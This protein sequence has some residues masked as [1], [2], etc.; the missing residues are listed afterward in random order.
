[1]AFVCLFIYIFCVNYKTVY[2]APMYDAT[3]RHKCLAQM[4]NTDSRP[5][6]PVQ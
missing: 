4:H 5:T 2:G 6:I 1:M 3:A